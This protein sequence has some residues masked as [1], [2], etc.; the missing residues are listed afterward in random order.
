MNHKRKTEFVL[1]WSTLESDKLKLLVV[2]NTANQEYF[3][4]SF[5]NLFDR[6]Q[7]MLS[8]VLLHS[9]PMRSNPPQRQKSDFP[10]VMMKLKSLLMMMMMATTTTTCNA[11]QI[12]A[13]S[14]KV[15]LRK[16]NRI[17]RRQKRKCLFAS[18]ENWIDLDREM[19]FTQ[20]KR[21]AQSSK[22]RE[23]EDLPPS[24][25]RPVSSP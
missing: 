21:L 19:N 11:L 24:P 1:P 10:G 9:R 20:R 6:A 13:V 3:R 15:I 8:V 14:R 18:R 12:K 22:T 16:R 25:P 5:A 7:E 17:G 2:G 4:I 23:K